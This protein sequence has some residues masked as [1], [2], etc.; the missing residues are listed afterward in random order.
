MGDGRAPV[1]IG[2]AQRTVRPGDRPVGELPLAGA[3]DPL[4]LLEAVARAAAE[5]AGLRGRALEA[6]DTIGLVESLGWYPSNGPRLLADRLGA[7]PR[8]ELSTGTGGE[9]PLVLVNHVARAIA[10]GEIDLALVAGTHVIRTLR[11]ART[12]H[13]RL[14]LPTGGEG[15][16]TAV[17]ESRPGTSEREQHYGLLL[18][19]TIYPLFENALR[20]RRGLELDEHR[21]R[22]GA[23]M[24]RFTRVAAGNP[25]AWFPVVRSAE[26]LVKTTAENRMIAFPYPKYLNA[27]L[28]TDQAAALL[29]ASAETA[30]RL[31]VEAKRW[32]GWWGGAGAVEDPWFATE[33]PDLAD[34]PALARATQGALGEAGASPAGLGHLDLYSCFP[35]AVEMACDLLG[36]AEDDA[37]GLTVTG[38]LPYAGGPGN[39]YCLH[40]LAALT[41][42][43]RERGGPGLATGNGW[44]LTKHSATVIGPGARE[45]AAAL[46]AAPARAAPPAVP[47]VAFAE[48]AE[49]SGV[50]ETYTVV[51]DRTGAPER[52]IAVGRLSDGRRFLAWL[53]EDRTLLEAFLAREEVGRHG[54]VHHRDG[55]NRFEPR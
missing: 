28:E 39:G 45:D 55:R 2:V 21:R 50:L 22:M 5:D 12:K 3:S 4:A 37:R 51:H 46:A 26:E 24:E 29:L 36:L 23:L 16:P 49:G 10:R 52:G 20:A 18:P 30:R 32:V 14:P 17:T 44:Y 41:E 42:R 7:K 19:T 27:V 34:C 33:R 48:E 47:P 15:R 13:V 53:P 11:T 31:G 38:G 25:H 40:S 9:T 43:V 1:L 54:R 8:R 6:L 35:V